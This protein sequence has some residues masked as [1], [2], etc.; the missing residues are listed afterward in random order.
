MMT[1]EELL[2]EMI[3][4]YQEEQKY[5][6]RTIASVVLFVLS[7]SAIIGSLLYYYGVFNV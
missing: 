4:A 5:F 2:N 6:R 1:N 3:R 7:V